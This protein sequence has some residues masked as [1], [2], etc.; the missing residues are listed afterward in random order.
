M[1]TGYRLSQSVALA[2]L[3]ATPALA[4]EPTDAM[5]AIAQMIVAL[6]RSD[7]SGYCSAMHGKPYADYVERSCKFGVEQKVKA[8]TDC[9]AAELARTVKADAERCQ[10]MAASEFEKKLSGLTKVRQEFTRGTAGEGV[11]GVKLLEA[12]RARK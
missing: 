4:L 1:S 3:I 5:R 8:T 12:E 10:A 2:C 6:E 9:T 11:D 7:L